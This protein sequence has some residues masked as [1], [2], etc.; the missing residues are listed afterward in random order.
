MSNTVYSAAYNDNDFIMLMSHDANEKAGFFG[1]G[2]RKSLKEETVIRSDIF[3]Y[4]ILGI[5]APEIISLPEITDRKIH[6]PAID[7]LPADKDDSIVSGNLTARKVYKLFKEKKG[8]NSNR[9]LAEA[10]IGLFARERKNRD[11]QHINNLNTTWARYK[12]ACNNE[13]V[14]I[15][16][17][18]L[19]YRPKMIVLMQQLAESNKIVDND[20]RW[21]V[22][23]FILSKIKDENVLHQQQIEKQ[24]NLNKEQQDYVMNQEQKTQ[25]IIDDEKQREIMSNIYGADQMFDE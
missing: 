25:S 22:Q 19:Q 15:I 7:Y 23:S 16:N 5:E 10:K 17:E 4:K 2:S 1:F 24:D 13:S 3:A 11:T 18:L 8:E 12:F 14:N 9:M 21:E 6:I 20:K